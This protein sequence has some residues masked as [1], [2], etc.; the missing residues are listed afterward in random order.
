MIHL[1]S[2]PLLVAA[3][4]TKN[5]I[6]KN[7]GIL[8]GIIASVLSVLGSREYV[9]I[10]MMQIPFYWLFAWLLGFGIRKLL[11]KKENSNE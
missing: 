7:I 5:P 1:F 10:V 8:V 2:F 4:A 3:F 9:L 6:L 11:T